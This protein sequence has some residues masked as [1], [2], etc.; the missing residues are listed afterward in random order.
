MNTRRQ[1]VPLVW[2]AAVALAG[3]AHQGRRSTQLLPPSSN[4]TPPQHALEAEVPGLPNFGFVTRDVWRG[5]QP[6]AIGLE[7]L[8]KLGLKTV[9]D[10]RENGTPDVL[11]PGVRIVRLPVSAWHADWVDPARLL[12]AISNNPKPVFIHCREG[13]DRTGMAVAEY[14]L[15]TGMSAA[16]ACRELLNFHVN[17]WWQIPIEQHIDRLQPLLS[18]KPPANR[19]RQGIGRAVHAGAGLVGGQEAG[20]PRK[21]PKPL[22]RERS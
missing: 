16:D 10:L 2:L 11:P 21:D 5:G 19:P 14:R 3:C 13:R 15:S 17:S 1:C 9:I 4:R 22:P 7:T 6:D 8:A 12:A 20:V 18:P